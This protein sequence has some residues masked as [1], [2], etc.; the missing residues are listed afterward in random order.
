[1]IEFQ[2]TPQRFIR[3]AA[4]MP[5]MPTMHYHNSYELYYL[6]AG[7]KK[8]AIEC[9]EFVVKSATENISPTEKLL[10]L[11]RIIC[12][13]FEE[14]RFLFMARFAVVPQDDD[15][16]ASA[17]EYFSSIIDC[18]ASAIDEGI[19]NGVF[20]QM[21]SKYAAMSLLGALMSFN[22]HAAFGWIELSTEERLNEV[23]N[24]IIKGFKI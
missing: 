17:K 14:H 9:F 22:R 2:Q 4:G 18:F 12:Q 20:R 16:A 11:C 7:N 13:D 19:K 5:V 21:N 10:N 15:N 24:I 3:T 8:K 6:E 1:M 23:E